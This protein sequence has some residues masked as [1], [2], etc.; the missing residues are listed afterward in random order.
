MP[1][2]YKTVRYDIMLFQH[3]RGHL[4]MLVVVV[5]YEVFITHTGF[6][7]HEDCGFHD[8]AEAGRVGV[9]CFEDHDDPV[10]RPWVNSGHLMHRGDW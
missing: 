10:I 2:T 1:L 9:A 4:R 3:G 6:L 5:L 7:L 8:F